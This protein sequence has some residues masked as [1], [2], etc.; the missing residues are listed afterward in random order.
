MGS[1]PAA[2]TSLVSILLP[3]NLLAENQL[4]QHPKIYASIFE[5]NK[6]RAMYGGDVHPA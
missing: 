2:A 3:A 1:N 4:Q 5:G 6:T